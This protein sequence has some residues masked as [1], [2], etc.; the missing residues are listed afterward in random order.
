MVCSGRRT[1][2]SVCR[3]VLSYQC[4]DGVQRSEDGTERLSVAVVGQHA[5]TT[6][7]E[8]GLRLTDGLPSRLTYSQRLLQLLLQQHHPVDSTGT[9]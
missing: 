1:V 5:Q 4:F 2:R 8:V 9:G 3:W 6:S 7:G